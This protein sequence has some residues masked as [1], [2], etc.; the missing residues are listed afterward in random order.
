[1]V[2][3]VSCVMKR[4]EMPACS[5]SLFSAPVMDRRSFFFFFFF[6][7]VVGY[8]VPHFWEHGG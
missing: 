6:F 1:M 3:D 7:S 2:T 4:G 8:F 5:F